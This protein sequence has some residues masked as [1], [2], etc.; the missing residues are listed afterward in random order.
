M[1]TSPACRREDS[2]FT[3]ALLAWALSLQEA[4][5]RRIPALRAQGETMTVAEP[6]PRVLFFDQKEHPW[7]P[8]AA[9]S[10]PHAWDL[11]VQPLN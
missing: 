6:L 3:P 2:S 4:L 1:E 10:L 7:R 8:K 9:I 5:G 11:R